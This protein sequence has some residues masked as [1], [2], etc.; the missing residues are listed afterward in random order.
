MSSIRGGVRGLGK[1]CEGFSD[2]WMEV[3]TMNERREGVGSTDLTA[4][5]V[6]AMFAVDDFYAE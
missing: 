1:H 5:Y 6:G 4:L 2:G 3:V